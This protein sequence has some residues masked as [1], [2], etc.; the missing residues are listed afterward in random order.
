M[1]YFLFLLSFIPAVVI[2]Q[3]KLQTSDMRAIYMQKVIQAPQYPK[4]QLYEIA[5]GWS[6]EVF[7][8]PKDAITFQDSIIGK[9]NLMLVL[10]YKI[11]LTHLPFQNLI[12][13]YIKN[14]K[15]KIRIDNI[16]ELDSGYRLEKYILKRDNTFRKAAGLTKSVESSLN[17]LINN[18]EN[19][20]QNY[21]TKDSN[22]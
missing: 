15:L 21:K 1:K 5:L 16:S 12:S 19:Y 17:S 9:I 6:S 11:G 22:W 14:Q 3:Q 8:S 20:I 4:H 2:G 7:L 13:I 18:L 10:N